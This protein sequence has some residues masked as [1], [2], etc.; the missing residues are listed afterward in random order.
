MIRFMQCRS[1]VYSNKFWGCTPLK[2]A[3]ITDNITMKDTLLGI[4]CEW[5]LT[6][7]SID[8]MSLFHVPFKS[9]GEF[10]SSSIMW[11]NALW[12]NVS[13]NNQHDFCSYKCYYKSTRCLGPIFKCRNRK[14]R[15]VP[16]SK[17]V[18]CQSPR[19]K[20]FFS[21][22]VGF[23]L[24][25]LYQHLMCWNPRVFLRQMIV[26]SSQPAAPGILKLTKVF[27]CHLSIAFSIKIKLFVLYSSS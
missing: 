23:T 2:A 24:C 4:S 18:L 19:G 16:G 8:W 14:W 9:S 3:T 1:K 17:P 22:G 21:Q 11:F 6:I 20:L 15:V 10:C 25:S 13:L 26:L 5:K 7:G 12:H 27:L